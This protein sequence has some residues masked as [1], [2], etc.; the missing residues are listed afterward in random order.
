MQPDVVDA[1][2]LVTAAH[3]SATLVKVPHPRR[4]SASSLKQGSISFSQELE[5]GVKFRRHRRRFFCASH[6]RIPGLECADRL[7][8]TT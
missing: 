1:F 2:H 4:L 3:S 5:V 8:R 6:S 7:S